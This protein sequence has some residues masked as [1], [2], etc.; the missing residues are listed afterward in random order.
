MASINILNS[1]TLSDKKYLLQTITF[2]ITDSKGQLQKQKREVYVRPHG[3]AILLYHPVKQTVLLSR[4][5]RLP[6]WLIDHSGEVIE[7]CAGIIDENETPEQAVIRE[8][9]EELGYKVASVTKVFEIYPSP[10]ALS[11]LIHLYIGEY[12]EDM[13]IHEGGGN[14]EEGEDIDVLELSFEEVRN[15]LKNRTFTDAKTI[16]LL[17][18]ALIERLI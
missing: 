5:F 17:Q 14:S 6:A 11:E 12:S 1:E 7:T 9:E 8:A 16:I 3:A 2:E 13:K 4:Q 15:M 18:H 10:G